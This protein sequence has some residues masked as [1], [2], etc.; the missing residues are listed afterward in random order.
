[1]GSAATSITF[2]SIVSS[3]T[4]LKLVIVFKGAAGGPQ[5]N[6]TFNGD[7][8]TNY[9]F[10][11]LNGNGT[12]ANSGRQ[13]NINTIYYG[14]YQAVGTSTTI[15]EMSVIDIFS[16]AGSTYKS[17]LEN[18]AA[19]Y[20]GSGGVCYQVGM[21]RSTAAITSINLVLQGGTQFAAGTTATLYGIKA[22]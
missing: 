14:D 10:T 8:S 5:G 20:N 7:T 21:W 15:P 9:S 11:R 6:L 1:L 18:S 22:A 17:I 16:Y 3:Y 19:N 12:T 2:S 4:D 13:A